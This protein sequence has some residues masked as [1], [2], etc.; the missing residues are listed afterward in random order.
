MESFLT[1]PKVRETMVRIRLI[2]QKLKYIL[3]QEGGFTMKLT[4][5]VIVP[6][7]HIGMKNNV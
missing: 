3:A 4:I 2:P 7:A 5:D 6:K 1:L